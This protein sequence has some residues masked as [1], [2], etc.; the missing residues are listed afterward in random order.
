MFVLEPINRS[1]YRSKLLQSIRLPLSI[2]ATL[3]SVQ[4]AKS[5]ALFSNNE[6]KSSDIRSYLVTHNPGHD[7]IWK[8]II[9]RE[10]FRFSLKDQ[11]HFSIRFNHTRKIEKQLLN[12][13][14]NIL[15]NRHW[16]R[17]FG[18]NIKRSIKGLIQYDILTVQPSTLWEK[19]AQR[20][21]GFSLFSR[22]YFFNFKIL[23][24]KLIDNE[25]P[26]K[27][28]RS[29]ENPEDYPPRLVEFCN[30]MLDN[31]IIEDIIVSPALIQLSNEK[32]KGKVFIKI[33][34]GQSNGDFTT[35]E[36]EDIN[37]EISSFDSDKDDLEPKY[38]FNFTT[39]G[40]Y[41]LQQKHFLFQYP[42][43]QLY[44]KQNSYSFRGMKYEFEQDEK[45]IT[46]A[47]IHYFLL[48][49]MHFRAAE[50][51]E[52]LVGSKFTKSLNIIYCYFL[53]L[54]H[55]KGKEFA[56]SHSY[57]SIMEELSP[58]FLGVEP[59]T[60][61]DEEHWELIRA[62]M[63]YFLK[64]IRDELSKEYSSLKRLQF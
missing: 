60:I 8:S 29:K 49:F 53:L 33:V 24:L 1:I 26:S 35:D 7:I 19:W 40:F 43:E 3:L 10:T 16:I 46:Q 27:M 13:K 48:Q 45:K 55:L 57:K 61:V 39:Y 30:K 11:D 15:I 32:I 20:L 58:Q 6:I 5:Y 50:Q 18:K 14:K 44:M 31:N 63:L 54:Q 38:V 22:R 52:K 34:L 59:D 17:S 25:T 36:L 12:P 2:I 28:L 4:P 23:S 51:Q 42:L 64:G 47:A 62:Q 56:I 37:D 9:N 41:K 21:A